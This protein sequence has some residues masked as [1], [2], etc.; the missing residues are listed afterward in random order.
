M[1]VVTT[2]SLSMQ[3]LVHAQDGFTMLELLIVVVSIV[4]LVGVVLLFR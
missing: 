1:N 3:K 4:I 2:G